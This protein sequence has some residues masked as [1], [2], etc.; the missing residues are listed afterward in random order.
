LRRYIA[1]LPHYIVL[2]IYFVDFTLDTYR[3]PENFVKHDV[4]SSNGSWQQAQLRKALGGRRFGHTDFVGS[5]RRRC[6]DVENV[7]RVTAFSCI[8]GSN[9][10]LDGGRKLPLGTYL[11]FNSLDV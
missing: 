11:T 8:A 4:Q 6:F 3:D 9:Q 1:L 7:K 10:V 5:K 2:Y